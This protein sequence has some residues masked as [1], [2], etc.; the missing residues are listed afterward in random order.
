M[1]RSYFWAVWLWSLQAVTGILLVIYVI[2]HT[3]DNSYILLGR[4]AFEKMLAFWHQTIP[5][6]LYILMVLGLGAVFVIHMLN[7]IRVASKP[8]KEVDL[9][10]RHAW[11]LKHSGTTFWLFQVLTGSLIAIF[12]VWHFIVQHAAEQTTTAAQSASRMS[13]LVFTVYVFL[14]TAVMFHSFNGVRSVLMKLGIMTDRKK[15]AILLTFLGLLFLIFL[16]L[17]ISSMAVFLK[18]HPSTKTAD[19]SHVT[20]AAPDDSRRPVSAKDTNSTILLR[21]KEN[22][23]SEKSTNAPITYKTD[24]INA[25]TSEQPLPSEGD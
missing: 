20:L 16:V 2:V 25:K 12:A 21:Q 17:G 9:T 4:Q 14:I 22:P 19:T 5:H 8:Y 7:G 3:L 6:P 11:M 10:W 15:E 23:P 24:P 13:P 18:S 1:K